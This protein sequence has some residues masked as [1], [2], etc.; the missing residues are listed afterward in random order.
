MWLTN[1]ICSTL[2]GRVQ[3][4]EELCSGLTLWCAFWPLGEK[5]KNRNGQ[6]RKMRV[7]RTASISVLAR[8]VGFIYLSS[9][10]P[11]TSAP[12][13]TTWEE[14]STECNETVCALP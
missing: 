6:M 8:S 1:E 14:Q 11:V 3:Q 10:L 4:K 2:Q 13:D 5:R 12:T 7:E 9:S